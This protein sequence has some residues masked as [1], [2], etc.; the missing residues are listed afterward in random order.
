MLIGISKKVR[1]INK[2]IKN[3]KTSHS[4]GYI[5]IVISIITN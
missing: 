2:I 5:P 3:D 4:R 1:N